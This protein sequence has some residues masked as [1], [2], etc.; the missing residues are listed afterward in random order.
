MDVH[1]DVANVAPVS[2]TDCHFADDVGHEPWGHAPVP[3]LDLGGAVAVVFRELRQL[4]QHPTDDGVE[5]GLASEDGGVYDG[6]RRD[7]LI[8][9]GGGVA[10]VVSQRGSAHEVSLGGHAHGAPDAEDDDARRLVRRRCEPHLEPRRPSTCS[11]RRRCLWLRSYSYRHCCR[12]RL[13]SWEIGGGDIVAGLE[14]AILSRLERVLDQT[15]NR[16]TRRAH[17]SSLPLAGATAGGEC[18]VSP[19]RFV[20]P[21]R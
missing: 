20:P 7:R 6:E 3:E 14:V 9:V 13:V 15:R 5:G 8:R 2:P 11:D 12:D 18:S 10:V 16:Q 17:H 4:R 21:Y 19:E 1:P